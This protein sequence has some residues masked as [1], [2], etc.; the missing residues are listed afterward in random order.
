MNK[1]LK[2]LTSPMGK[3]LIAA[4]VVSVVSYIAYIQY[5]KAQERKIYNGNTKAEV[6][7][8]TILGIAK[9]KIA[10]LPIENNFDANDKE[11][12]ATM[13]AY[14]DREFGGGEISAWHLNKYLDKAGIPSDVRTDFDYLVY[15]KFLITPFL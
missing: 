12:L 9:E 11:K 7:E 4:I 14:Y 13:A 8:K 15:T 2:F 6:V 1:F 10:N 3:L 5:V